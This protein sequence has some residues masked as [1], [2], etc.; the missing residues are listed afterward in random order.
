VANLE[1]RIARLEAMHGQHGW[2]DVATWRAEQADGVTLDEQERRRLIEQP[3]REA[4]IREMFA[5]IRRRLA[6]VEAI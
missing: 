1:Q 5:R 3:G 4:E 2:F 6:A